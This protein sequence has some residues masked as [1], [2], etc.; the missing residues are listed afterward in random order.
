MS[1]FLQDLRFAARHLLKSPGFTSIAI[2]IMALGIGANTAIF[3]VVHAVLLEPL[4]YQNPDRLVQVV[5]VPPQ[6]QFPG[7]KIFAVSAANFLDWQKQNDV[8]SEMSLATGGAF[9]ITGKGKPETIIGSTVNYNFFSILGVQPIYGRLFLPQEDQ[10]GHNAEI[11]LTYKLWQSHFGSDPN[12]IGR[13]IT[14][15]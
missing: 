5:H 14:L 10:P 7:M 4:P 2:L 3:S 12:V 6:S 15:D 1:R 8:F 13:T 9:E 11:I